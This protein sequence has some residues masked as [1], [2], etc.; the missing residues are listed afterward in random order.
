MHD[1]RLRPPRESFN[2]VDCRQWPHTPVLDQRLLD[3]WIAPRCFDRIDEAG[4][5]RLQALLKLRV[6]DP[7][8]A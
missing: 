1:D 6:G 8:S 4:E 5:I 3:A 7:P 2:A